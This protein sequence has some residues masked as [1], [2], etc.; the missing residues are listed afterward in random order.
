M[1]EKTK[2]IPMTED[3]RK[4]LT[5][6]LHYCILCRVWDDCEEKMRWKDRSPERGDVR[7]VIKFAWVPESVEGCWVWLE[8]YVSLQSCVYCWYYGRLRWEEYKR[9]FYDKKD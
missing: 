4:R 6:D 2:N 9:E 3:L 7:K 5:N 1:T 8:K